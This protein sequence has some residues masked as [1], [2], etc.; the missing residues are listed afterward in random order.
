MQVLK[1]LFASF[2]LASSTSEE[3]KEILPLLS[4]VISDREKALRGGLITITVSKDREERM[5]NK[6]G[7]TW[8]RGE[9]GV[10]KWVQQNSKGL[11][12]PS[13]IPGNTHRDGS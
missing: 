7:K 11:G 12:R 4:Y 13:A 6:H 9:N 8:V 2:S 10:I 5:A 1:R 3:R